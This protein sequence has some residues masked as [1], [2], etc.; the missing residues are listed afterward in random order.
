MR[1]GTLSPLCL[2]DALPK[3]MSPSWL[4]TDYE[5]VSAAPDNGRLR[6]QQARHLQNDLASFWIFPTLDQIG[7]NPARAFDAIE[8]LDLEAGVDDLTSQVFWP[9][10]VGRSEVVDPVRRVLVVPVE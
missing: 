7:K 5:Q 3:I 8:A 6:L 2:C 1:V 4:A 9:M 10:E